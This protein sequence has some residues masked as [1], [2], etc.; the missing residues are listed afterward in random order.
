MRSLRL[1]LLLALLAW[2]PVN[3]ANKKQRKT[4]RRRAQRLHGTRD[5]V[6]KTAI[7]CL[8]THRLYRQNFDSKRHSLVGSMVIRRTGTRPRDWVLWTGITCLPLACNALWSGC[9]QRR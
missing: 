5:A 9:L 1:L 3:R 7:M 8:S 2:A 6:R 4:G